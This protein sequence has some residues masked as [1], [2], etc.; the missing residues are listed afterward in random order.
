MFEVA[1]GLGS[2][3]K[4]IPLA[5]GKGRTIENLVEIDPP[6]SHSIQRDR[7]V[8][9]RFRGKWTPRKSAVGRYNC[10]GMVWASRRTCILDPKFYEWFIEDDGYRDIRIGEA[11]LPGDIAVYIDTESQDE[12]LHVGRVCYLTDKQIPIV[13]SKWNSTSGEY[14]HAIQDHPYTRT[15]R[16][17]HKVMTDRPLT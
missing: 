8:F 7:D 13:L 12:I 15:H 5:T 10:A 14:F 17:R 11:P 6:P 9:D 16:V 2:T 1:A 4:S 3:E